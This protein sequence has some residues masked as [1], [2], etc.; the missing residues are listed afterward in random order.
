MACI[1]CNSPSTAHTLAD[2]SFRA[3]QDLC[4]ASFSVVVGRSVIGQTAVSYKCVRRVRYKS[5]HQNLL[6]SR[7]SPHPVC[8]IVVPVC[9]STSALIAASSLFNRNP[10]MSQPTT[11]ALFR[12]PALLGIGF[13][14]E[15][16]VPEGSSSRAKR[17][18]RHYRAVALC[19][20][21]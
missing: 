15:L 9:A 19:L 18:H 10:G 6:F 21:L 17:C 14:R 11:P 5:K 7:V 20:Q 13:I 8:S 2:W 16:I 4:R 3:R 1:V 12:A